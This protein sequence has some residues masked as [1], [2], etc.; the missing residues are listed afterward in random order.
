MRT[1]ILVGVSCGAIGV[2]IREILEAREMNEENERG[3]IKSKVNYWDHDG[4]C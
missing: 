3:H 4:R 2:V 1:L